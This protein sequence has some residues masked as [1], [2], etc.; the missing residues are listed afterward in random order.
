LGFAVG[1][2]L[3]AA[4]GGVG[5]GLIGA[6]DVFGEGGILGGVFGGDKPKAPDPSKVLDSFL[7]PSTGV[8]SETAKVLKA[9][10][11]AQL[12]LAETD[13]QKAAIFQNTALVAQQSVME[14]QQAQ[15]QL[16]N[17][18]ALQAQTAKIFAPFAESNQRVASMAADVY[19]EMKENLTPGLQS[20][21]DMFAV[22]TQQ[23]ADLMT[24]GLY[25]TALAKPRIDALVAQQQQIDSIAAQIV[26]QASAQAASGGGVDIEALMASV[27]G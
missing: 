4:I 18:L 1:G 5:G 17:S 10:A 25:T 9:N 20:V 3:G 7:T 26:Q 21:A 2:P 12:E 6:F 23:Q 24:Q 13:E 11:M 15:E 27:G 19:G 22:N 16:A 14:R 8:D